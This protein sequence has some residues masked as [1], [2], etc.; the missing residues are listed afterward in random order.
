MS[1]EKIFNPET[2]SANII[3]GITSPVF[4]AGRIRANIDA[5]TAAEARAVEVYRSTVLNALSETEDALIACRRS[6]ERLATIE[7]ATVAAREANEL[8]QQRYQ[9]GN[10]DFIAPLDAQRT[11]LGL[12]E[13]F[14]A[15]R[16][17]RSIA[18]VQLYKAL[19][20]GWASH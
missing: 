18:F 2:T 19:G 5:N 4:D 12:E 1:A 14:I 11:V 16:L 9:S 6:T 17:D 13:S 3:A 10:I 20:G 15:T 7:K 8:A